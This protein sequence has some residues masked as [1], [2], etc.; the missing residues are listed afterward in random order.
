MHRPD[1]FEQQVRA[2]VSSFKET[3]QAT[4]STSDQAYLAVALSLQ[5]AASGSKPPDASVLVS[6]ADTVISRKRCCP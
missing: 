5:Q 3:L 6:S 2:D 1:E 4:I